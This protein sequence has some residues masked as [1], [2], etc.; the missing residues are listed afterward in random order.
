M[1]RRILKEFI[2]AGQIHKGIYNT[3]EQG[4]PQGGIISP[5]IA[6]MV[7]NGL[8]KKILEFKDTLKLQIESQIRK[9]AANKAKEEG[10]SLTLYYKKYGQPY[11]KTRI[12]FVRYADD[13]LISAEKPEHFTQIK[14]IIEEFLK[15]RGVELN[16]KKTKIYTIEEGF[17]FLGFNFRKYP[18][19]KKKK[20]DILLVRPSKKAIL[21]FR[22]KV[23]ETI[24]LY[25]NQSVGTLIQALNPILRG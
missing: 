5:V 6:N 2:K 22:R 7:L 10:I 3:T 19:K 18:N 16:P 9:E 13:F 8:E 11:G 1:N 23:T 4:V 17:D 25:S 24:H 14:E 21:R 15:E 20:G 12:N